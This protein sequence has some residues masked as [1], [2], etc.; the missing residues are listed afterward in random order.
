V[1]TIPAGDGIWHMWA[2]PAGTQMWVCNDIDKTISV[3]DLSSLTPGTT[4]PIPADLVEAGGKPHD[5]I[6]DPSG[7]F[8]YVTIVGVMGV[9]D[10]VVKYSA[11]TFLEVDRAA[12]GKDPHLSLTPANG[13]LYV[14]AQLANQV[15]VLDRATLN[16]VETIAVPNAHGAGMTSCG[17]LFYA[18]NITG[19]GNDALWAIDTT[20]NQVIAKPVDAPHP[21]PHNLALVPD[22]TKIYVTHSGATNT[23]V[24]VFDL[25]QGPDDASLVTAVPVG[26][27]PF[28]LTFVSLASDLDNDGLVGSIDLGYLLGAWGTCGR[29]LCAADI[30]ADGDVDGF[31]LARLL[32]DWSTD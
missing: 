12:V 17:D 20:L 23:W 11:T 26:A 24:S 7:A 1:T 15:H 8:A 32:A 5:V 30:D 28:G 19:G 6:V 10:Y 25:E 27:N 18:T 13:L 4:F 9:S 31:D 2:N 16:E 3:L 22:D 21:T 29:G 14:P